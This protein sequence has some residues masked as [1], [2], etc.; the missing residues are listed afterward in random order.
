MT[1]PETDFQARSTTSNKLHT[2]REC[3]GLAQVECVREV[4]ANAFPGEWTE[5]R[6]CSLCWSVPEDGEPAEVKS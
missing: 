5:N 4:P 1:D 2:H 6:A 3:P